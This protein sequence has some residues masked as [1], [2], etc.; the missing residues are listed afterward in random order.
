[1]VSCFQIRTF[2][3]ELCEFR[4]HFHVSL[5]MRRNFTGGPAHQLLTCSPGNGLLRS[6]TL[7]CVGGRLSFVL[8]PCTRGWSDHSV[9]FIPVTS[10]Q[11]SVFSLL[12]CCMLQTLL[13]KS[14]V[15]PR[16]EPASV[17]RCFALNLSARGSLGLIALAK[18][19]LVTMWF[20]A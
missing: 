17:P 4:C 11:K 18:Y 3:Q 16:S 14:P 6:H 1:M 7:I 20:L 5:L 19:A 2:Y 15:Y 13:Q 9:G 10:A 12:E 8:E